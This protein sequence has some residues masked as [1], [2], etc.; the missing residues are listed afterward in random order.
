M[1]T[2]EAASFPGVSRQFL[3]QLLD[4]GSVP[5]HRAGTH[6]R[7]YFQDLISF[8]K[9]RD[10]RRHEAIE[11]MARDAVNDGVYDEF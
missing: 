7:V 9:E 11:Q 8:R 2:Q 5:F 4:Q 10:R 3:V 1:T 6:R